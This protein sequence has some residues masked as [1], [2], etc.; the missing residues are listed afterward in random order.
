[1][2][3]RFGL[4]GILCG[5]L[6]V[7]ASPSQG[8]SEQI[9][10]PS[11]ALSAASG[12]SR[13]AGSTT[14]EFTVLAL[15]VEFQPDTTRFTTGDGTFQG[16]PYGGLVPSVDPLPHDAAFFD[17]HLASLAHYIG[18]VSDEQATLRPI[19]VPEVVRVSQRM[20][21]YTPLGLDSG[22][23]DQLARL[24]SLVHEAWTV[25]D[26]QL[27]FS[28]PPD[29]DPARTFFVLFHAGVGRDIELVGTTLDKTPLD[30][31]SIFF[32]E[33]SLM[34]LGT[35]TPV[36]KGL[37][38]TNS[39]VM[40]RTE[41]RR[42]FNFIL[43]EPFLVE[44][45][46]NGL[47]AASF[48][49]FLGVPDL[50]NTESGESAI[51]P[52]GLMDP[53]GIFAYGGLIPPEPSAWTK[54]FLGWTVPDEVSGDL[55]RSVSLRAVTTAT[56]DV[57]RV[58]ISDHEYFLLENRYRDA[59][60]D[61]LVMQVWKDGSI[62]EQR[63]ANGDPEF[64]SRTTEGF[65]GGVVV[66][67]DEYD[68]ALPGGLDEL[69]NPLLGGILIW[70]V[71]ER[72]IQEGIGS[73][74]VN[75]DPSW[76]GVD[77]EEAD[78]GQDLG[79]P[80]AGFFGP[81]LD[82][83]SPFDFFYEGNPVTVIT[84]SG[85]EVT[86]YEN[87]FGNDTYPDSRTNAGGPSFI[88]I[89]DFSAPAPQMSILV[90]RVAAESAELVESASFRV[91]EVVGDVSSLN[92]R[93]FLKWCADA[94]EPFYAIN[95]SVGNPARRAI[96]VGDDEGFVRILD[97]VEMAD[98]AIAC[99]SDHLLGLTVENGQYSI[100]R[101]NPRAGESLSTETGVSSETYSPVSRIIVGSDR[102]YVVLASAS[103]SVLVNVGLDGTILGTTELTST[104]SDATYAGAGRLAVRSDQTVQLIDGT[105]SALTT[106]D[107]GSADLGHAS[108]MAFGRDA[109]G[110]LGVLVGSEGKL[111]LLVEDGTVQRVEPTVALGEMNLWG[112]TDAPD[113]V[114]EDL[115][116]D[117]RLD[118][119]LASTG[120]LL[121]FTRGGAFVDG[122]PVELPSPASA[123]II[124]AASPEGGLPS[125][126]VATD[127]GFVYAYRLEKGRRVVAGFP[128]PAG[129][130]VALGGSN[131]YSVSSSGHVTV[132]RLTSTG[133]PRWSEVFGSSANQSFV[134][135]E[136]SGHE[137]GSGEGLLVASETYNWP[138]PVAE[139]RT[140]FRVAT[141]EDSSLRITIVDM[142]GGQVDELSA[143]LVR[144]GSAFEL[145]WTT[146]V[147]SGLYLAR[148][149]ATA[150]SGR[151]ESRLVKVAVIR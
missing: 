120:R 56:S 93:S 38:V 35:S 2:L 100:L 25:A 151:S 61:G 78:S 122:Y 46:T 16:D 138:N 121:A 83:G 80:S 86:L 103:T 45:T 128:L 15:R 26:Q 27:D 81:E 102:A 115:D 104:V 36:F 137:I 29:V 6:A 3:S 4:R 94:A 90:T 74:A 69:D 108:H 91:D 71:D 51:G 54:T 22:S 55:P 42:G 18:T 1:M 32:D 95:M 129:P 150:L 124:T 43:D 106:W 110:L 88:E 101:I 143:P 30:V 12:P 109:A 13:V 75:T 20:E 89:R 10:V 21:A 131:L 123:R 96:L 17:A 68:W 142:A 63:I 41:T 7:L 53:L 144:A 59:A 111:A 31:P 49:N 33:S 97:D 58:W 19:L 140:N 134:E 117:G 65:A 147:Q 57:A 146:A 148:V 127:D 126:L 116:G 99:A 14:G 130:A 67:V 77:V 48:L 133:L 76:R 64:N 82:L 92:E 50:F 141:T 135:L 5:L 149:T 24:S 28:I 114:L 145:T 39:V 66:G 136:D 85:R 98:A 84:A 52:F 112:S 34:R 73:N 47:L 119:V 70:H 40:P 132:W 113:P 23:D 62:S 125:V 60:S 8:Q 37:P 44:L 87:R 118:V 139:G 79:F 72:K 105:G 107:T 9:V 11:L